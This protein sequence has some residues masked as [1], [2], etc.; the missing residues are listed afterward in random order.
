VGGTGRLAFGKPPVDAFADDDAEGR[1]QL[2]CALKAG[3]FE[4]FHEDE[5]RVEISEDEGALM[6]FLLRLF[7]V[8]SHGEFEEDACGHDVCDHDHEHEHWEHPGHFHDRV[9]GE[10]LDPTAVWNDER[11]AVKRRASDQR[12]DDL[13]RAV[14]E[15]RLVA[16]AEQ[17]TAGRISRR[18][19]TGRR[20]RPR[21]RRRA[22]PS[23]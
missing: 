9:V 11:R 1:L 3:A 5:L 17:A 6:F 14:V 2:G 20:S 22:P 15:P 4:A 7:H 13:C 21:A 16:T 19:P 10:V 12:G 18:R 8:H 23:T